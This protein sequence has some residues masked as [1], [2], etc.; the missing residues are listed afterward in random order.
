MPRFFIYV[1]RIAEHCPVRSMSNSCYRECTG[2]F[3]SKGVYSL[4]ASKQVSSTYKSNGWVD[5]AGRGIY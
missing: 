2:L 4:H 3:C 5:E 1:V